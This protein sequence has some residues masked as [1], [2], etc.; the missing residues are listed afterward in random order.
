MIVEKKIVLN[1]LSTNKSSELSTITRGSVLHDCNHI[2]YI[3]KILKCFFLSEHLI[4]L[5]DVCVNITSHD[6]FTKIRI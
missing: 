5:N 1:C 3:R 4:I 6:D 2:V